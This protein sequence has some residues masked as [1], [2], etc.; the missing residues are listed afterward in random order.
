MWAPHT[1]TRIVDYVE[2]LSSRTWWFQVYHFH[3]RKWLFGDKYFSHLFQMIALFWTSSLGLM[4]NR[5]SGDVIP[6]RMFE[7]SSKLSKAL[8]YRTNVPMWDNK[9]QT[10]L[11]W[12]PQR[13][14]TMCSNWTVLMRMCRLRFELLFDWVS[15]CS[16][17]F[18][19]FTLI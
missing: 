18:I 4:M 1:C 14:V 15:N 16:F 5:K 17:H 8:P 9:D 13:A 19:S 3:S 7:S 10:A 2:R 11:N 12:I 6:L